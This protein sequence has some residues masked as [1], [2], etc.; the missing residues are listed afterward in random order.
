M[1][2]YRGIVMMSVLHMMK[3]L[4]KM[5]VQKTLIQMQIIKRC[6]NFIKSNGLINSILSAQKKKLILS[7]TTFFLLNI[8][9]PLIFSYLFYLEFVW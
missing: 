4:M 9:F 6:W 5:K 7:T 1:V 2:K 3:T 8:F